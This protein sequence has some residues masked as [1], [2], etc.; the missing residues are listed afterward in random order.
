PARTTA[1]T[2][3]RGARRAPER[4]AHRAPAS[5]RP[6]AP[7][8]NW[9]SWLGGLA[10][11]LA[12][13]V[14]VGVWGGMQR[15]AA[16]EAT[17]RA[18]RTQARVDLLIEQVGTV[19]ARADGLAEDQAVLAA[20][21]AREDADVRALGG[22]DPDAQ[23]AGSVVLLPDGRALLVM[24]DPPGEGNDFQA[25]G[26]RGEQVTSLGVFSRRVTEVRSEAFDAVAV[27]LEPS[28]GSETPT[29]VLGAAPAG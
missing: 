14:A 19:Q 23:A 3:Q 4:D 13:T 22:D 12:L 27:S 7:G 15:E 18:D 28:G 21:L 25:W 17:A 26:V 6:G 29:R 9:P 16:L 5:D 11:G 10:A 2:S 1:P 20:W 8:T 24:R